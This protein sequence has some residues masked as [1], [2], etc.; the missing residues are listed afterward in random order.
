M[1][2]NRTGKVQNQV[3]QLLKV[4]FGASK[5]E[6][7][8]NRGDNPTLWGEQEH[9]SIMLKFLGDKQK[10]SH[11][12]TQAPVKPLPRDL[13]GIDLSCFACSRRPDL[14]GTFQ[15]TPNLVLN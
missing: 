1:I 10:K 14:L 8:I 11:F 9:A 2:N 15:F 3:A 7:R 6:E 4:S 5:K 12:I 13:K